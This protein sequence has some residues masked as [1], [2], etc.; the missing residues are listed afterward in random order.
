[1]INKIVMGLISAVFFFSLSSE[2]LAGEFGN[3]F[4]SER[5]EGQSRAA[6]AQALLGIEELFRAIR[7]RELGEGQ[8]V[9]EL[10]EAI[11]NIFEASEKMNTILADDF[12][13][14][15]LS[16]G[17][18]SFVAN[19]IGGDINRFGFELEEI[20]TFRDLF[21]SFSELGKALSL[22]IVEERNRD[23]SE[24]VFPS[25]SPI[26]RGY[27]ALGESVSIISRERLR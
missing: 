18:R 14:F 8:G 16:G 22:A 3:I 2:V 9:E 26:L 4:G 24:L 27:L 1:M 12:P 13:D 23:T 6:S 10:S 20:F 7:L 11:Q 15:E 25:I 19:K 17:E 5:L 21:E